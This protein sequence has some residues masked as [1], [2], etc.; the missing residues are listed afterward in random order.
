MLVQELECNSIIKIRISYLPIF[1][2]NV[3]LSIKL[4]RYDKEDLKVS[5]KEFSKD[6]KEARVRF[7]NKIVMIRLEIMKQ[8]YMI[9]LR[10]DTK[11]MFKMMNWQNAKKL[12]NGSIILLSHD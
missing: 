12:Q 3:S 4:Y 6:L 10:M 5:I 2:I 1:D 7:F 8:G 11:H 9:R